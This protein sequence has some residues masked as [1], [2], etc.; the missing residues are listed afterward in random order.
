MERYVEFCGISKAFP[1]VQA[2]KDVSFKMPGGR[3]TA[4]VGENGAGKST[5]LKILSG[6]ISPD[7]G[8]LIIDGEEKKFSHPNEAIK[9]SVSVI[10]QERQLVPMLSVMENI[11]L[12]D[13]P[14]G[15]FG[16]IKGKELKKRTQEMADRFGLSIDP[17]ETVGRLSVAYQ[18]MVEIMKA[19]RRGSQIIAF[20]EPTAP[21]TDAEINILFKLI[22]QLK[23]E[24]KVVAYVSHRMAE[25][26]DVT[27]DIVVM[28]DG[29]FV[30]A[31]KTAETD[32]SE[33]IRSMVGRDIG[34]T[35]SGLSRNESFG[36]VLLDVRNLNTE[37]VHD[38]SF[39]LRRGEVLG[40]AGL[41]GAGRTEV[42]RA[43]FGVDPVI[44]GEILLDGQSAV[45]KAPREAIDAGVALCPEDRKEQ[46]LIL[47]RSI[48]ENISAPVLKKVSRGIFVN[49]SAEGE[50][51]D[52]AVD[53]YSIKTPTTDKITVELSGGNQQKVIL[54]RWTSELMTT[55]VL[56]LDEPTK[57]IDVGTK[58]EVYQMVCDFAKEGKGVIFIS[59]ELTEILSLC[60]RIV[61]MRGGRITGEVMRKDATE[62]S[63]LALA[64]LD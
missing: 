28:K 35:Y 18:Q 11:F 32:A 5:L 20:D 31:F 7:E 29:R 30:K 8:K 38:V 3:V 40:F 12:D 23:D 22:A 39:T 34:D 61:V 59:S 51:A 15:R 43:V 45:F 6:D 56:I 4:L 47:P 52:A 21:L 10:Y 1:G 2:L 44:S 27:D 62:E 9:S 25:I 60:D 13:L 58:A 55:K 42:M 53:R 49:R 57:G 36:G 50:L 64:M 37:T 46:G 24:G 16:F 14:S 48:T 33:L 17:T 19:Y 26:F 63:V 54:A 41:V